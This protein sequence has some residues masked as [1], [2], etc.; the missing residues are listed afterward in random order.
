MEAEAAKFI[1]AGIA[2]TPLFGVGLG[3]GILFASVITVMGRNPSMA[4]N[5]KGAGLFYFALVEAIALFAL[6]VA[7][8]MLF[9]L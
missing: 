6:V 4:D 8:L 5:V 7:L 9:V 3:L 2:V 1:G